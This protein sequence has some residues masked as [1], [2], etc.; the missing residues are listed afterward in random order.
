M[1]KFNLQLNYKKFQPHFEIL[2]TYIMIIFAK[3]VEGGG[4]GNNI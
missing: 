4:G 2:N 3:K 1:P